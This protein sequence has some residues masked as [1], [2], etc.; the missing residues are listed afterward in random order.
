MSLVNLPGPGVEEVGMSGPVLGPGLE[1]QIRVMENTVT[2]DTKCMK[3][4]G[5]DHKAKHALWNMEDLPKWV[6]NRLL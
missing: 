2:T 3:E 1:Y 5:F 4:R 6:L